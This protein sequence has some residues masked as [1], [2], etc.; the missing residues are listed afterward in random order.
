MW[1]SI[2]FER[3]ENMGKKKTKIVGKISSSICKANNISCFSGYDIV[4]SL[5]LISHVNKH[6]NN[7]ISVDSFNKTLANVD[8]VISSPYFVY[9]DPIKNSLRYYKKLDEF[10]CVVVNILNDYSFVS[11]IYPVNKK[12]ID[13]LKNK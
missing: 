6:V 3:S 5:G 13:K 11:T 9:Y 7:F 8:K 12:T 1:A 10:V 2:F 4:Q